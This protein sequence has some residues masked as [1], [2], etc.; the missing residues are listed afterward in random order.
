MANTS[1]AEKRNRQA[2]KR[3]GRNRA[4]RT[5]MRTAV[6]DLREKV[7]AGEVEKARDMLTETLKLV[8][9]TAQ[10]GAIHRNTA[11]RTKR[12]LLRAFRP[13]ATS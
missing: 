5:R 13:A 3:R 4:Y 10:K 6:K 2:V 1:S 8:D 11:A 7:A 9:A 12:R